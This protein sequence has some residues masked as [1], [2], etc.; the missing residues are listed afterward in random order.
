M[1]TKLLTIYLLL[2][3]LQVF[4]DPPF[5]S[6]DYWYL[7]GNHTCQGKDTSKWNNCYDYTQHNYGALAEIV[8]YKN[9]M[10]NGES[11]Y[12]ND[13]GFLEHKAFYVNGKKEGWETEYYG[14]SYMTETEKYEDLK[15]ISEYFYVNGKKEGKQYVYYPSGK[16][17][18]ESFYKNGK[19]EGKQ[20]KYHESGKVSEE[21]FY[22]NGKM[23]KKE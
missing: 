4:A 1:K 17:S 2:F 21:S 8:F 15:V 18:E 19:K 22:K 7:I 10:K 13:S 14:K 3:S 6:D 9:G 16:V 5:L 11:N 23:I 20:Y 12:Y